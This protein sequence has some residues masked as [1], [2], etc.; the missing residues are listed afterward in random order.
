[1]PDKVPWLPAKN[2]G[3]LSPLAPR[4]DDPVF[5]SKA[6][7]RFRVGTARPSVAGRMLH[8]DAALVQHCPRWD[9][10]RLQ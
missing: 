7:E 9:R 1:M 10:E 3:A 4:V 8:A 6:D 2:A 5:A